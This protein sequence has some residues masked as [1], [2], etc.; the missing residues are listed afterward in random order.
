MSNERQRASGVEIQSA[1]GLYLEVLMSEMSTE[2]IA[3]LLERPVNDVETMELQLLNEWV[4]QDTGEY[5]TD[6]P[7]GPEWLGELICDRTMAISKRMLHIWN[8]I[9]LKKTKK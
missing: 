9:L 2:E 4:N 8:K 5:F 3:K 7:V 6:L 1:Y